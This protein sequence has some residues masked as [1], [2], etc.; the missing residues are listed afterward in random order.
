MFTYIKQ[1]T[2]ND[3]RIIMWIGGESDIGAASQG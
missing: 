3:K 2:K 1:K